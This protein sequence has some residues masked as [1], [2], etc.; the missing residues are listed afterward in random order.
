MADYTDKLLGSLDNSMSGVEDVLPRTPRRLSIA[1]W[2]NSLSNMQLT[3]LDQDVLKHPPNLSTVDSYGMLAKHPSVDFNHELLAINENRSQR[4]RKLSNKSNKEKS[5]NS[6]PSR[7]LNSFSK[8]GPS[9]SVRNSMINKYNEPSVGIDYGSFRPSVLNAFMDKV[10]MLSKNDTEIVFDDEE[11][12]A[13]Q[14]NCGKQLSQVMSMCSSTRIDLKQSI[15]PTTQKD[16][17]AESIKYLLRSESLIR[18]SRQREIRKAWKEVGRKIVKEGKSKEFMRRLRQQPSEASMQIKS[19]HPYDT[20][21]L[22]YDLTEDYRESDH[23]NAHALSNAIIEYGKEKQLL[24]E[25][26][27]DIKYLTNK[28][29]SLSKLSK[30]LCSC[31]PLSRKKSDQSIEDNVTK[32]DDQF[33]STSGPITNAIASRLL[34]KSVHN[35]D[36]TDGYK[37]PRNDTK[38]SC[39][40]ST[41]SFASQD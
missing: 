25:V 36:T 4:I 21:R 40:T 17:D 41:K 3:R 32:Y 9:K 30:Y 1:S 15:D 33:N 2:R 31:I 13:E 34:K 26:S 5:S 39:A 28:D 23:R 27:K 29:Q 11:M 18:E 12:I 37:L 24:D 10:G 22:S 20:A 35:D 6:I 16:I 8:I 7:Q 19:Y 14:N 38:G